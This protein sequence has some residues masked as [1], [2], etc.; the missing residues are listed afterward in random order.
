VR[1]ISK[2]TGR[3]VD[4]N[5]ACIHLTG[6]YHTLATPTEELKIRAYT[7]ARC[8]V[9]ALAMSTDRPE[10]RKLAGRCGVKHIQMK[11]SIPIRH[12]DTILSMGFEPY[13]HKFEYS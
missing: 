5:A 8:L 4:L 6:A 11:H 9:S 7:A 10:P 1:L 3:I 13:G 12:D 2:E